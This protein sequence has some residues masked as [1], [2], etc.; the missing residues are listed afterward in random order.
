MDSNAWLALKTKSYYS[1]SVLWGILG[2]KHLFAEGSPYNWIYY[3]FLIGPG[4][5]G[6]TYVV[7]RYKPGWNIEERCNMTMILYGGT[8]F[9]VYETTNLMTSAMLALFFMGYM[10]RYH[11]AWFRKYNYL[12]G[13]G[14]DCGTQITQTVIMFAINLPNASMPAWWG[15]NVSILSF[16]LPR[17]CD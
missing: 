7:H 10:L 6:I 1:L 9:P 16:K 8:I 15:N 17:R 11:P 13:V 14:L 3:A 5:V 2:P 4:L 12:L